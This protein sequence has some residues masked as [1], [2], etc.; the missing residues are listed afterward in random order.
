MR[1]TINLATYSK[2]NQ[3]RWF[4]T[5]S[6]PTYGFDVDMDVDRL[7]R[8]A[9]ERKDSFFPY[10]LYLV[11]KGVN[12]IPEMR[13]RVVKGQLY[14]YDTIHPTWTVMTDSGVYLNVGMEMIED[15]P[16][17][18][19]AVKTLDDKSKTVIPSDALDNYVVGDGFNVIYAT[20][21][22]FLKILAVKHPTPANNPESSSVP[23][24]LWDQYRLE[25]NGHY[26]LTL[27]ITVSHALVDGF[28]LGRCFQEIQRYLDD[29]K[30]FLTGLKN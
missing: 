22:P 5:F 16:S 23:R 7:V 8:L 4:S 6:D 1:E 20:C 12:A 10:F 26:H 13:L 30:L 11:T 24:I 9:K 15:F 18:Y 28:P 19:K 21:I 29:P 3:Y 17:F 25:G 27:N 2:R 14:R